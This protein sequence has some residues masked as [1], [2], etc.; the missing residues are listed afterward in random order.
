MHRHRQF[1]ARTGKKNLS[2]DLAGARLD[3]YLAVIVVKPR[4]V[5]LRLGEHSRIAGDHRS[6]KPGLRRD[7]NLF[8]KPRLVLPVAFAKLANLG[9]P[10]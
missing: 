7:R 2:A 10:L 6:A 3:K 5:K 8:K 4:V 1:R 9:A